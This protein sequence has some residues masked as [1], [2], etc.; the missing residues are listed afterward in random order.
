VAS[1]LRPRAAV[2]LINGNG[3]AHKPSLD[4][5]HA[6]GILPERLALTG[7]KKGCDHGQC[8]ACTMC[9]DGRYVLSCLM[10]GS[11]QTGAN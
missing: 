9:R 3:T 6:R 11:R 10:P 7:A 2:H 5:L 4:P 8:G 1:A